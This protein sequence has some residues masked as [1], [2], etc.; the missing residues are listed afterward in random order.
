MSWFRTEPVV[1][2]DKDYFPPPPYLLLC[3]MALAI[4]VL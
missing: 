3:M 4:M 2:V 1:G